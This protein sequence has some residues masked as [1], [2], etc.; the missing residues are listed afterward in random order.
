MYTFD[1]SHGII[2]RNVGIGRYSGISRN[3]MVSGCNSHGNQ[4]LAK[5]VRTT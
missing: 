4:R 5:K 1:L 2:V 3:D